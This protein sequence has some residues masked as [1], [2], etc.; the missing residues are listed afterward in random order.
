[1][2][3]LIKDSGAPSSVP[4]K[5]DTDIREVYDIPLAEIDPFPDHPYKVRDDEDMMKLMYHR[6]E[7]MLICA[8]NC[9]YRRLVLGAFGCGAF[10]ND[11]RIVSDI[12]YQVISE[13]RFDGKDVDGLFKSIDFAVL[14]TKGRS[15][16]FDEFYRNFGDL[17][18][19]KNKKEKDE[20]RAS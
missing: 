9:G 18:S 15:Y 14:S 19:L 8:A 2:P 3:R 16:N 6:I 17:K 1:M 10:N 20:G 4:T 5:G 7:G 13:F 12:F 11:A